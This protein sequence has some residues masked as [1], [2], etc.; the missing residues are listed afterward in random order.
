MRCNS[1]IKKKSRAWPVLRRHCFSKV[2]LFLD[3]TVQVYTLFLN[4]IFISNSVQTHAANCLRT[5]YMLL[6]RGLPNIKRD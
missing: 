3:Y 4:F 5:A 2:K 1:R 6:A